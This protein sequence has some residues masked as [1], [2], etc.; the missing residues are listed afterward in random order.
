MGIHPR[1]PFPRS[2]STA[3]QLARPS[4]QHWL[5]PHLHVVQ[6]MQ[7]WEGLESSSNLVAH[8]PSLRNPCNG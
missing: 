3:Q 2:V 7:D 8:G 1:T 5:A 6:D 4:K